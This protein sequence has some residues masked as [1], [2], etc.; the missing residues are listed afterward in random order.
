MGQARTG[1]EKS[2][3]IL[4]TRYLFGKKVAPKTVKFIPPKEAKKAGLK[5]PKSFWR[6]LFTKK[7]TT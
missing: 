5:T 1:K 4:K 2:K 6:Y 7:V 3:G